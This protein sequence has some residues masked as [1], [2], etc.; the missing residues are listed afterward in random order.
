MD[1]I[2]ELTWT[3]WRRRL[4]ALRREIADADCRMRIWFPLFQVEFP[5]FWEG[6][7][8]GRSYR[9]RKKKDFPFSISDFSFR[10]FNLQVQQNIFG[11]FAPAGRDVHSLAVLSLLPSSVGAKSLLLALAIG[12][13]PGFAPLER[14]ES[15]VALVS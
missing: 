15:T 9:G 14:N 1:L 11:R 5:S 12:P 6:L 2:P 10:G 13:L 8:E 3:S 7:G 4:R